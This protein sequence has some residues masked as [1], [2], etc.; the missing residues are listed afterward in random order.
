MSGLEL[1]IDMVGRRVKERVRVVER[2]GVVRGRRGRAKSIHC[3]W[4][5]SSG[6]R[7]GEKEVGRRVWVA[8]RRLLML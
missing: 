7:G 4:G 3:S 1:A 6:V 5:E 2:R 8:R